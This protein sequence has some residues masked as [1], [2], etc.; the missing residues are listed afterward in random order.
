MNYKLKNVNG[1][2]A[3]LLKAGNDFVRNDI[4]IS[5]AQHIIDTGEL[6]DSHIEEYPICVDKRWYFACEPVKK[7]RR[8]KNAS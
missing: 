3:S 1:K 7:V 6:Y 2:V 4:P 8:E 5:S